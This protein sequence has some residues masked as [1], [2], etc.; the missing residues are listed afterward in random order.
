MIKGLA[1]VLFVGVLAFCAWLT[2]RYATRDAR[3]APKRTLQRQIKT[4]QIEDSH[5]QVLL[6]ELVDFAKL[7]R[8]EE[9]NTS[10]SIVMRITEY[11]TARNQR[12]EL[13]Q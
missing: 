5:T 7:W 4:L 6:D 10:D 3:L 8:N 11:R 1:G 9:P 12:K 13:S 2:Y